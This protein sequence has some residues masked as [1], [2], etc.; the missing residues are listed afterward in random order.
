MERC[1]L[2][3]GVLRAIRAVLCLR[4]FSGV[5]A[6]IATLECTSQSVPQLVGSQQ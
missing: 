2:S 3:S 4:N 6:I 1:V 5:L